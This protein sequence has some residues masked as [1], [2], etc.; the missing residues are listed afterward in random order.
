MLSTQIMVMGCAASPVQFSI[1][2]YQLTV[3]ICAAEASTQLTVITQARFKPLKASYF[4][5]SSL[6]AFTLH[7]SYLT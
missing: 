6:L 3:G 4:S 1:A 5:F 2:T 7:C